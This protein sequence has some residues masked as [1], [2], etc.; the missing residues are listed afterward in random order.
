M[1]QEFNV[2]TPNVARVYDY[3][4]GGKDNC[5]A[6][7]AAAEDVMDALPDARIGAIEN[8]AFLQRS[9]RFLAA[10]G[11]DQ[12]LDIGCGLPTAEN[13]HQVAQAANPDARVCYVDYDMVVMAHARALLA[14]YQNVHAIAADL[15]D[16]YDILHQASGFISAIVRARRLCSTI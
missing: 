2:R 5:T 9:V 14:D 15:K 11:I 8:R 16:P 4:L 10:R 7:R 13:T 6:D 1:M 3:F 12:F